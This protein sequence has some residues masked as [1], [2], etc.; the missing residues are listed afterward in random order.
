MA[1]NKGNQPA[2]A[3]EIT[4]VSLQKR[5]FNLRTV[6]T[7]VLAVAF[8]IFVFTRL[9]IDFGNTWAQMKSIRL[10]FYI[11][12]FVVYY[13]SFPIRA[14]RWRI[15]LRNVGY[16]DELPQLP[17]L[18][19]IVFLSF[20]VNCILYA[21]LGDVY[22]AYLLKEESEVSFT[23]TL[24]TVLAE[25]VIDLMV[26]VILLVFAALAFWHGVTGGAATIILVG[27]LAMLAIMAALVAVMWRF[28]NRLEKHLPSRFRS[29]YR[30]FHEGTLGSFRKLPVI[31]LLSVIIW[32]LE[33]GRLL[34]VSYAL[35]LYPGLGLILFASLAI[36]ILVA[37]PATPGGLGLVE[38]GLTGLFLLF[39]PRE[40]ASSLVLVD[41]TISYLSLV[42]FG[43]L[44]FIW[45]QARRKRRQ[46]ISST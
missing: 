44:L 22:R 33:A 9:N 8:L 28:G 6:I 31:L 11:L 41:R 35:G 10:H 25:R 5:F 18:T 16:R 19:E 39:L 45:I 38:T 27:G 21:R 46:P 20:F 29:L 12:A 36:A 3:G 1:E 32:L 40:D 34:M 24:G 23:K 7:F 15:M 30:P 26:V 43:L 17:R 42:V 13:I 14:L 37:L 4:Q 2:E